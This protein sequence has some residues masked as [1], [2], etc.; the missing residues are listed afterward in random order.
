[1]S[2]INWLTGKK[3]LRTGNAP[4]WV[5]KSNRKRYNSLKPSLSQKR[6]NFIKQQQII[7]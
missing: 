6:T 4:N 3:T 2:F 1:M 5:K 7:N